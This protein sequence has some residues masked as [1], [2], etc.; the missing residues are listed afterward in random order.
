MLVDF[1][2]SE[3]RQAV[4]LAYISRVQHGSAAV[5]TAFRLVVDGTELAQSNTGNAYHWDFRA[6]S[7]HGV[8]SALSAGTYTAE[9]SGIDADSE[10][11]LCVHLDIVVS[12]S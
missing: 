1:T 5:N 6:I 11:F 8:S 12:G 9:L 7:L 4:V 10:Q 3:A 2:L